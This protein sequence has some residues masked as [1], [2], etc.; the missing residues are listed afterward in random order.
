MMM[1]APRPDFASTQMANGNE[2]TTQRN[3]TM[4]AAAVS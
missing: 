4:A 3:A 2:N 1:A